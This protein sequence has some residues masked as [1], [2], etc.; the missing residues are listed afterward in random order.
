MKIRILKTASNAKAVQIV[1]YQ[2]NK[3]TILQHIGSAHTEAELNEL[4]TIAEEWMKD[5]SQQ[6]SVFPDEGP[7]KL[8][9]LYNG[10]F[11]GTQ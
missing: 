10:T 8:I 2:N 1:R 11:I 9:Y 3:Q 4:L 5:F 6:L 7:N